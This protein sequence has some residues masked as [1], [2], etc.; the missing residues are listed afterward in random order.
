MLSSE[1]I[2]FHLESKTKE[3]IA[4]DGQEARSSEIIFF[5]L[6]SGL[7]CVGAIK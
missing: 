3:G 2:F 1:I 7:W 5:H 4:W 6:E